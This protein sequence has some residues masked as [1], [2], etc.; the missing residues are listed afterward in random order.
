MVAKN[1]LDENG[2]RDILVPR[3]REMVKFT[4]VSIVEGPMYEEAG[5]DQMEYVF[6]YYIGVTVR[7]SRKL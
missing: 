5:E 4:E 7:S 6:D 2:F 1:M 3:R